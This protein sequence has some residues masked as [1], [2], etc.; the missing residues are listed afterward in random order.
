LTQKKLAEML[1]EITQSTTISLE[2]VGKMMNEGN[3]PNC[4]TS[5]WQSEIMGEDGL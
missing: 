3:V 2:P 5:P 4:H 1:T